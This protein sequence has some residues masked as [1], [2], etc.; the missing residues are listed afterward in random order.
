MVPAGSNAAGP[1][2][3]L[4]PALGRE[5]VCDHTQA[6]EH[7]C[8]A[9]QESPPRAATIV[10]AWPCGANRRAVQGHKRARV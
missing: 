3:G 9:R 5:E 10:R 4:S 6:A 7:D 2:L 8:G 1:L